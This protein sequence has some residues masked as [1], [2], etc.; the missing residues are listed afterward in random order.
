MEP[1]RLPTTCLR[2]IGPSYRSDVVFPG[3]SLAA[4]KTLR[5]PLSLAP[6]SIMRINGLVDAWKGAV[7][8]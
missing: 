2:I 8:S 1:S 4:D 7:T 5:Q 6:V 3:L